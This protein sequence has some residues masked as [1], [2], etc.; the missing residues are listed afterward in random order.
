MRVLLLSL[1]LFG[2]PVLAVVETFEFDEEATR[3]RYLKFIEE[4]RCP[5]CQNQ[6]LAGSDAPI[7]KDLRQELHRLLNEGLSD[8]EIVDYMVQRYGD[9][10]LYRPRLQARTVALW[11]TPALLLLLA[12]VLLLRAQK[13][14]AV[15]TTT[16]ANS[17]DLNDAER[18]R[19]SRLLD[20]S[21][22]DRK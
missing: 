10:I 22:E 5:K 14:R 2:G 21:G 4:L 7:A 18:Q 6:N 11:V 9:Y 20:A 8:E 13:R 1:L 3:Q 17:A 12:V 16:A 15:A 19:L